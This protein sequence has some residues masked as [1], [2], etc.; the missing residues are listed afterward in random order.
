[1][2]AKEFYFQYFISTHTCV[3]RLLYFYHRQHMAIHLCCTSL[4]HQ[5][6]LSCP[7][8]SVKVYKITM[9]YI[10]GV[11]DS[12]F[13]LICNTYKVIQCQ[14]G[15]YSPEAICSTQSYS[16][17]ALIALHYIATYTFRALR[18]LTPMCFDNH[19]VNVAVYTS[20]IAM[21]C[22]MA[23]YSCVGGVN[24]RLH[25]NMH[26]NSECLTCTQVNGCKPF[27]HML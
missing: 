14:K 23:P 11:Q 9:Y 25:I 6:P 26:Q 18:V 2:L 19:I 20:Y 5:A 4:K 27:V 17:S 1:M 8:A 7:V 10:Y 24:L 15:V 16:T 21:L 13:S 3:S 12:I 22:L